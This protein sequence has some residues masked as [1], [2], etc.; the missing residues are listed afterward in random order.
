MSSGFRVEKSGG[1][2]RFEVRLKTG[3][4]I[5][6][7]KQH[8]SVFNLKGYNGC[9]PC[10]DCNNCLGHTP[11]FLH[12]FVVHVLSDEH[13]RFIPHTDASFRALADEVKHTA[14]TNPAALP[15][16]EKATGLKYNPKGLMWDIQ[17][18]EKLPAPSSK[19]LDWMHMICASGGFGQYELNQ[20]VLCL[21]DQGITTEEIDEWT[22]A[23]KKPRGH[24]KLGKHF[25]RDRVVNKRTGKVRAFAG[26]VL[27]AVTLLG[28]LSLWWSSPW[29]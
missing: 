21:G 6:D 20:V 24:Q 4:L 26:E 23:V 2:I 18:R 25:F 22:H 9:V 16:H 29:R 28:F 14:E 11:W 12:D 3:P 8:L 1:G 17:V 7:W 5:A 13:H 15:M 10:S 27:S 19:F